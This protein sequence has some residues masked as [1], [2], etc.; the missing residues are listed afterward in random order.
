[1]STAKYRAVK[2]GGCLA[3]THHID[4]DGVHHLR[5]QEPLQPY[6]ARLTDRL[7]EWA[8]HAPG[9][10]QVAQRGA[11]GEWRR[12]P[13]APMFDRVRRVAFFALM[14]ACL[15]LE[16]IPYDGTSSEDRHPASFVVLSPMGSTI[17]P[18]A[19]EPPQEP[20]PPRW[21]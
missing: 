4:A 15:T 5:S 17:P 2:V 1:M 12:I 6:P 3:A 11:D 16:L 20:K 21:C 13:Y 10:T 7:E 14:A 9:R 19:L 8:R 18:M